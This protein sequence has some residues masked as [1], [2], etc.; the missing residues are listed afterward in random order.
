MDGETNEKP[1]SQVIVRR[2]GFVCGNKSNVTEEETRFTKLRLVYGSTSS[3]PV[4]EN[5][6]GAFNGIEFSVEN[7]KLP[8]SGRKEARSPCCFE[9]MERFVRMLLNLLA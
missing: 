7:N 9:L 8:L 4:D 3:E 5:V 2:A 6:R 1:S